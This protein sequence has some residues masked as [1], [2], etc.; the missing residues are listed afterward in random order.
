MANSLYMGIDPGVE[1][2][3]GIAWC[4][5]D[6]EMITH[7][8]SIS[9]PGTEKDIVD[10]LKAEMPLCTG[11]RYVFIEEQVPRPTTWIRAGTRQMSILKSTCLLYGN[12]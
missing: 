7:V 8:A 2:R 12:Y 6:H 3:G 9:M 4:Y 11:D 1:G 5:R 10:I